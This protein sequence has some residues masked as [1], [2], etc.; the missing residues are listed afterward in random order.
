[1]A[2]S[3]KSLFFMLIIISFAFVLL[4]YLLSLSPYARAVL[5]II[6]LAIDVIAFSTKYY[7]YLFTPLLHS[8]QNL[9]TEPRPCI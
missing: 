3:G 6:A 2:L 8:K 1:M 9:D 5:A 7:T 4:I